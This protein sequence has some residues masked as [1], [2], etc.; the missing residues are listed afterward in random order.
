MRIEKR[1]KLNFN[2][3]ILQLDR[4]GAGLQSLNYNV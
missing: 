2:Y 1:G 4:M 3:Y